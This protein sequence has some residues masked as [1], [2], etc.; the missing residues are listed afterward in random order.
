MQLQLSMQLDIALEHHNAMRLGEAEAIYQRILQV[1]PT[2]ADALHLLGLLAHQVDKHELGIE[3]I[4]K[5]ISHK[6][7]FAEA[8]TN[9]GLA[10]QTLGKIDEARKHY[11]K[12]IAQNPN[13]VMAHNNYGNLLFLID[14]KY[15]EAIKSFKNTIQIDPN[16]FM[17]HF[18]LGNVFRTQ[19]NYREAELCLKKA[20]SIAP[21]SAEAYHQLGIAYFM[22]DLFDDAIE[23]YKKA[24]SI[25]SNLATAHHSLAMA[26]QRIW[27]I[28]EAVQHYRDAFDLN[29]ADS[30]ILKDMFLPMQYSSALDEGTI[31][32][33]L[34]EFA[35]RFESPLMAHWEKHLNTLEP[36]RKLKIGYVSADLRT[37]PIA[38]FV[39]PVFANHNH[40]EFEIFCYYNNEFEDETTLRLKAMTNHWLFCSM[41]DDQLAKRIR[42]DE[43]D[44][45]VDLSGHTLGNRLLTFAHKPAPIQISWMGFVGS[46][47]LK[48]IDYRLTDVF[49]EPNNQQTMPEQPW[50]LDPIWYVYRPC[51]K[52]PARRK[53]EAMQVMSTPALENKFITFGSLNN[54]SKVTPKAAQLW[55]RI[56]ES[57]P[58]SKL[59]LVTKDENV[60]RP[61][62]LAQFQR[63]NIEKERIIFV[64]Y[65][66]D[67]HY[68][69][70]H[71]IDIALDPFP[72]SGGTTTC[73]GLWMGVPFI[74][75]AGDVFR[76][77]MGVT[78]AQN[79]G[80]P[81]WIA[82]D[83]TAYV[84]NACRLA[85]DIP[86][87]NVLRLGLRAE[88]ESSPL[89]DEQG[90]TLKLEAAYRQMWIKYCETSE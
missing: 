38:N 85:A 23:S 79:V 44:I 69:L 41:P 89:M 17:G 14:K 70:Y 15:E 45:L 1:Q 9:L 42:D 25:D 21:N 86:K 10:K 73:D 26:T 64:D 33:A 67:N 7:I 19:G 72:Y 43:I 51:I 24:I 50:E 80:H 49:V 35:A 90:F 2:N 31:N 58:D 76:S 57:N 8:Y 53:A 27:R 52:N 75:L 87:L 18:N 39:E 22:Q 77:R 47:G 13:L 74:T 59:L 78:I 82:E 61:N 68:L 84:K 12:A 5:A 62:V 20:L 40:N 65:S 54:I 16:F 4:S 29:S 48:S 66:K 30:T 60:I 55:S 36:Q 81:E 88:M 6:P 34:L 71:Q 83:E 28:D 63:N 37:H 11:E 32:Q 46:T 3:L 56:L